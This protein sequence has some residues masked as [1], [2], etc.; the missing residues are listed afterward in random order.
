[1]PRLVRAVGSGPLRLR[2]ISF[3]ACYAYGELMNDD[4]AIK[5]AN[6]CTRKLIERQGPPSNGPGF[7]MPSSGR[8]LDFY[9]VYSVHQY[10]MAPRSSVRRA[11]G[12]LE[13]E[14]RS[15]AA[16]IGFSATISSGKAMLVP[17]LHLS[18]RS[19][20]RKGE[21]ARRT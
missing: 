16:L 19:Q 11:H 20:V 2:H 13:R 9:E 5:I 17:E 1:M 10:G 8:V 12:V 14:M 21:F 6:V 3:S 15:S 4:R 18:I 7:S